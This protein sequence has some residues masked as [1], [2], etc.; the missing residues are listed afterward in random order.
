MTLEVAIEPAAGDNAA[1]TVLTALRE[2]GYAGLQRVE[3]AD[4]LELE[5]ADGLQ[6]A[7]EALGCLSQAEIVFNPNKHKLL[8][9]LP[10]ASQGSAPG[11]APQ[12][13]ALV[14]D[15]ED[16]DEQLRR[17]LGEKF[18]LRGLR[19]VRRAVAWRLFDVAGAAPKERLQWA[20]DA[21]LCNRLSQCCAIRQRRRTELVHS[22][23]T[24]NDVD[25]CRDPF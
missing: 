22:V 14:A 13:E 16:D 1:F 24:A 12:W 18:G 2:L 23:H 5:L 17:L 8:R 4:M 11:Y 20:G 10:Q 6:T 9:V 7:E 25:N 19:R 15:S 21:L 3:R